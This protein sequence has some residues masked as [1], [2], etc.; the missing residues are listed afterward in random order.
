MD[1]HP[2]RLNQYRGR[3][4]RQEIH[5]I[6][7]SQGGFLIQERSD[8]KFALFPS[9]LVLLRATQFRGANNGL[10]HYFL[11]QAGGESNR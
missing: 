6:N 11:L 9:A 5:T 2:M 10:T 7:T 1:S 4:G 8:I 3:G